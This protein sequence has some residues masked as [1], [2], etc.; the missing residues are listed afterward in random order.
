M[1]WG[2]H[3]L[4]S[5]CESSD[6]SK[7]TLRYKTYLPSDLRTVDGIRIEPNCSELASRRYTIVE[8]RRRI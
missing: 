2:F 4:Q 7:V 1:D 3:S 6:D 8:V 5:I